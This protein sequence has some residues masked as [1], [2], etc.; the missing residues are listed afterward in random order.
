MVEFPPYRRRVRF[1]DVDVY[2]H[3]FNTRYLVYFD[4]VLTDG[5]AAAGIS[6]LPEENG[7]VRFVVAHLE[8]DFVGEA[9][10][11]DELITTLTVERLGRTS[12]TFALETRN[13]PDNRVVVRGR[14]VYVVVDAETGKPTPIPDEVRRVFG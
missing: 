10:L 2:G 6:F 5:F 13:E 12:I 9:T 11:G 1:W 4:D 8:C 7:G 3:V 14:E